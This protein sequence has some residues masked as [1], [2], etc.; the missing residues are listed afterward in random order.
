MSANATTTAP[1]HMGLGLSAGR[2]G[3]SPAVGTPPV[4]SV[5]PVVTVAG[6]TVVVGAVASCTQGTWTNT[7]TAYA[8]QW[9]RGNSAIAGAASSSYM[10]VTADVGFL[11]H[12]EVTA[13]NASGSGLASS[14]NTTVVLSIPPVNTVAPAL[15]V[16]GGTAVVA[17]VATCTQGTW[18]NSPTGYTYQWY[19]GSTAIAGAT[20]TTYTLTSSDVTYA[21]HCDVTATNPSGSV[22]ASSNATAAVIPLYWKPDGLLGQ[23]L[24]ID[25]R[26][27]ASFGN[28]SPVIAYTDKSPAHHD[29]AEASATAPTYSLTAANGLPGF[30]FNSV[31]Q[32]KLRRSEAWAFGSGACTI[33]AVVSC[34]TLPGTNATFISEGKTGNNTPTYA[35]IRASGATATTCISLLTSDASGNMLAAQPTSPLAFQSTPT[36]IVRHDTGS[37]LTARL[38]GAQT[39]SDAYVRAVTSL[40]LFCIGAKSQGTPNSHASFVLHGMFMVTGRV[41]SFAEVEVWEGYWCHELGLTSLLPVDHPFKTTRPLLF[42][43]PSFPSMNALRLNPFN[44]LSAHHRAVGTG[45][46][47]KR[48]D[49]DED[50]YYGI[51]GTTGAATRGRMSIVDRINVGG[52]SVGRKFDHPVSIFDPTQTVTFNPLS[53]S[54]INLPQTLKIPAANG[55]TIGFPFEPVSNPQDANVLFHP[56]NGINIDEAKLFHEYYS[57]IFKANICRTYPLGDVDFVPAATV[58]S[59][60]GT[61][62]SLMRWPGVML[63]YRE[64]VAATPAPVRHALHVHI[65]RKCSQTYDT[66]SAAHVLGRTRVWPAYGMDGDATGTSEAPDHTFRQNNQGDIPYGTRFV[67]RWRDRNLRG[68]LGL[69]ARGQVLFDTLLQYGFYV[70]DGSPE[71]GTTTSTALMTFRTDAAPPNTQYP[72]G[73]WPDALNDEIQAQ[74]YLM[75]PYFW[76]LRVVRPDAT[77]NEIWAPA[78]VP[79][80]SGGDKLYPE[81]QCNAW[82]YLPVL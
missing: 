24:W 9:F 16:A 78:G 35:L 69:S 81:I 32:N 28:V 25:P 76:P 34:P 53:D 7:P 36:L 33:I 49:T 27:T 4:N 20:A 46:A 37:Q 12:C 66:Q 73:R 31:S 15:T 22:T 39:D 64:W 79:Y 48:A 13:T 62:A 5:A 70:I 23:T 55:T 11:M 61:S 77:E 41:P 50:Q 52:G 58:T 10:L 19:R 30:I 67:I 72:D 14:N 65:T 59:D 26:D 21:L 42:S 56:T 45:L 57:S 43:V 6:G 38:N 63:T 60:K 71:P 74:M 44:K 51:P 2:V 29:L 47:G 1:T 75:L 18:S 40:D 17:A 3:T 54:N 80:A 8:Y 82:D 68:T